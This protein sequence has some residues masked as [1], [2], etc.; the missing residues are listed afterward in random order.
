[1]REPEELGSR[2]MGDSECWIVNR[3][4]DGRRRD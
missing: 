1:L 2:F 4:R 3:I